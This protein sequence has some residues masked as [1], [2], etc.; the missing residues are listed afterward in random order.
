MSNIPGIILGNGW[1]YNDEQGTVIFL[2]SMEVIVWQV[3]RQFNINV[4]GTIIGARVI[5]IITPKRNTLPDFSRSWVVFL[6]RY[7]LS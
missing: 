7:C 4:I 1:K 6:K 3:K 5:C 2:Y